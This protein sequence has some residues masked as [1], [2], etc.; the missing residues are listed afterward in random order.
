MEDLLRDKMLRYMELRGLS[1][2]A[3][4]LNAGLSEGAVKAILS[5]HSK[6]PRYDTLEKL[7]VVLGCTVSDLIEDDR[8]V[9]ENISAPLTVVSVTGKVQAGAWVEAVEWPQGD[10]F[11]IAVPPDRRYPGIQRFGLLVQ[12]PSM[13]LVYPDG[14][15]LI[16]VAFGDLG[17][18]AKSGERVV[19]Q[20]RRG[21]GEYEMT[22][23][24]YIVR[25][26]QHWLVPRSTN[27]NF[28]SPVALELSDH[29][30]LSV[31]ALVVGSYRPE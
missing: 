28:Q 2:R 23:K 26:G 30:D 17:R 4:S 31:A 9:K 11:E 14:T 3:L 7:A 29:E 22:V 15:I 20:R 27:P 12:G 24:E 10:W 1:R 18:S 19:C 5:G 21:R 6:H 16:C 25:D 13:D 8:H